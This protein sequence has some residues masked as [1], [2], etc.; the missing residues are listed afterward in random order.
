MTLG[1]TSGVGVSKTLSPSASLSLADILRTLLDGDLDLA[2][3]DL[4]SI[5]DSFG[6]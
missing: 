6:A 5:D 2:L 1:S 4:G 3:G